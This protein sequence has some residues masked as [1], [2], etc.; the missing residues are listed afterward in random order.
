MSFGRRRGSFGMPGTSGV[1][2]L[3]VSF[4]FS[5]SLL[6][7]ALLSVMQA[8]AV[9]DSSGCSAVGEDLA[10]QSC[11]VKMATSLLIGK[12][13]GPSR[14]YA[15]QRLSLPPLW[16]TSRLLSSIA[17]DKRTS[18]APSIVE[19]VANLL[20]AEDKEQHH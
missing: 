20:N 10:R 14:R 6:V 15:C 2:G 19:V 1:V 5:I 18:T 17:V 3:A 4:W 7:E 11:A 13:N 9:V 16:T 8:I 12:R